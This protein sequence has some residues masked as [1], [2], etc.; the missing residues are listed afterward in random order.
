M[1]SILKQLNRPFNFN[2]NSVT[3]E[4]LVSMVQEGQ[5]L[6]IFIPATSEKLPQNSDQDSDN[7]IQRNAERNRESSMQIGHTYIFK[8]RQYMTKPSTPDFDF[9]AKWNDNKPMPFRVMQ[10]K[11]LKE[12]P[13]MFN[14]ECT[15]VPMETSV[16]MRCGRRL[17]HPVS[18]LYG[19]GPECGE[20]AHINPFETEEELY[21][22]LDSLKEQLRQIK[23]TGWVIKSAIEEYREVE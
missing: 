9:H 3:L 4:Q 22:A 1:E 15:V 14:M 10:G 21:Q 16:C 2:G 13:G 5:E 23:W 19:I 7:S 6:T 17:T 8:V 11:V 18:R 12:T 20:H